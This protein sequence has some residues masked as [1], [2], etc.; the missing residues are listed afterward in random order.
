M[1]AGSVGWPKVLLVLCFVGALVA[2][3]AFDVGRYLDLDALRASREALLAFAERHYAAALTIA[4]VAYAAAAALSLPVATVLSLAL[5][6]LFGRWIGTALIV[7]AATLGATIAF[8]AARYVFAAAA[9]RRLGALGDRINA[10]F[11]GHAWS[12]M[13]FL[14][15]VP[16]FPFFLVNLAAAFTTIGVRTYALATLIGIMPGAF[17]YA[18]LGQAL[19]GI[20]STRG[21]LSGRTLFALTLL[22]LLALAPLVVR[23]WRARAAARAS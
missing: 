8:L 16:L 9:R 19:A 14:R 17:V 10:G 13:L 18:N 6:F 12:W 2:F 22:G 5:G 21:L 20:E 1:N 11:T 15:L 4:F 3:Y 7:A 23:K